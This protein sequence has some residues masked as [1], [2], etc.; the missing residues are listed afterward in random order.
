M[1]IDINKLRRLAQAATPGLWYATGKLTR[2]VEVRIDG[3]LIQE[4]AACGPT[5]ADGG[6]GPQQ[7]AN[8]SLI[9]AANPA[10]IFELLDRLERAES[11]CL[12]QAR[13]NGMG[14]EREAALMAKL[15]AA[16]KERDAL[17]AELSKQQA[18][19]DAAQHIA[20]VAQSRAN[21]LQTKIA[22]LEQQDP[23]AWRTFDG[24]GGYDYRSYE[25]NENY[26]LG[27]DA[28]NPNHIGWV[29][30]LY[31]LHEAKGEEKCSE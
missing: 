10:T 12:E 13:L 21:R 18:L 28:R 3:G 2:Y 11:K 26:K 14:S 22:E 16:E 29:E 17:S 27:W 23:V 4:V 24:E 6:Y 5:I 31:T 9:A 15:E 7:E 1:T 20:G 25:D 19:T 8:A 30:P